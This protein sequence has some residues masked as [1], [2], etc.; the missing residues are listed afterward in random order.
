MLS[1]ASL[2]EVDELVGALI[3]GS[4]GRIWESFPTKGPKS[5]DRAFLEL[6]L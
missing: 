4:T 2:A 6:S 1:A 3:A 5:L